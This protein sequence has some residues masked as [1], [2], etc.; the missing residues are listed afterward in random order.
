MTRLRIS[1]LRI[2]VNLITELAH[3]VMYIHATITYARDRLSFTGLHQVWQSRQQK[4]KE[5]MH[6]SEIVTS[7]IV[8][9]WQM[10]FSNTILIQFRI[11]ESSIF[12]NCRLVNKDRFTYHSKLA[13]IGKQTH[14]GPDAEQIRWKF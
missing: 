3:V 7:M 10:A 6:L 4:E 1:Y 8:Q 14:N 11:F 5:P 13:A 2:H 12:I 9:T